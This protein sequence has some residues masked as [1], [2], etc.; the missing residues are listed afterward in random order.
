[1]ALPDSLTLGTQV[2]ERT[3][4]STWI[5]SGTTI[6]EPELFQV[7]STINSSAKSSYV[8]KLTRS[9]NVLGQPD[10]IL[11]VHTVVLLPHR[12]F[13]QTDVSACVSTLNTFLS[14][15]ARLTR[16]LRGEK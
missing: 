13:V 4:G 11:Q 10:D 8:I 5:N 14:D 16:L 2:Y 9:K 12:S 3:D 15:S 1:M 7:Q 6:D